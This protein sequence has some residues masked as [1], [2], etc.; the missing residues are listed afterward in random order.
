MAL[1]HR[2]LDGDFSQ[3]CRLKPYI[4]EINAGFT[5]LNCPITLL[6]FLRNCPVAVFSVSFASQY[7]QTP[8]MYVYIVHYWTISQIYFYCDIGNSICLTIMLWSYK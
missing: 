1:Q 3:Q 8:I 4:Y 2:A 7:P 5:I 6:E